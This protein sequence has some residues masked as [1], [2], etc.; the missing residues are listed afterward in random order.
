MK[1]LF[2]INIPYW[3]DKKLNIILWTNKNGK[4]NK[5]CLTFWLNY[6]LRDL[7]GYEGEWFLG[8]RVNFVLWK[9]RSKE[10]H[11]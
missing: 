4:N 6:Q 10:K 8:K 5:L 2:N 3:I 9:W 11:D 7:P 1:H